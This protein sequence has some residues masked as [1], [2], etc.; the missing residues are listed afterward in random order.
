M[1][2]RYFEEIAMTMKS[3]IPM[4]IPTTKVKIGARGQIPA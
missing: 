3:A 2:A 1:A 4:A